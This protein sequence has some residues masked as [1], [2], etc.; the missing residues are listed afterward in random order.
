MKKLILV[1][2][3]AAT[4]VAVPANAAPNAR[5][6]HRENVHQVTKQKAVP[7]TSRN[8]VQA[9]NVHRHPVQVR[10]V[11]RQPVQVRQV[12]AS[13]GH[14]WSRGQRFDHRYASNY[15]V[16]NDYRAYHLSAPP[17]GYRYVQS[18]NDIVLVAIV[19]GIIGAVFGNLL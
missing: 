13:R 17:Y 11:Y 8:V 3:A 19:S 10:N 18:G 5:N 16:I 2:A 15:R 7:R 4:M 1:A 6:N 14:Q 12:R 9:R